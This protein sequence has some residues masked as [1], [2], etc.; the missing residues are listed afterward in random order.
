MSVTGWLPRQCWPI[1]LAARLFPFCGCL[2][3]PASITINPLAAPKYLRVVLEQAED[4]SPIMQLHGRKGAGVLS[5]LTG[6]D[7]LIEIPVENTGVAVGD[8]MSFIPFREAGL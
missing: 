4:G 7:G 3:G 1:L 5:S 2:C 8:Y 6:A